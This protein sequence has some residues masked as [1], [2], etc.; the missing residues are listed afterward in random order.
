MLVRNFAG[1][2]DAVAHA[3]HDLARLDLETRDV[4]YHALRRALVSLIAAFP[5]YRTYA[6]AG[7]APGSDAPIL[8]RAVEAAK[9]MAGP[10]E[11]AIV[12]LVNGW[13]QG[14][15]VADQEVRARAVIALQQLCAPVAAK[16][17]EGHGLLPLR[18]AR[19]AQRRRLRSRPLRHPPRG[20]PRERHGARGA[21]PRVHA[22]HPRHTTTSAARTCAPAL[23]ALSEIPAEWADRIGAW[24]DL[25]KRHTQDAVDPA[26]EYVLYQMLLGAWPYDLAPDDADGLAQLGARLA[27]WQEKALRE[28]KLNSSWTAP[29]EDY[30][31]A[32]TRFVEAVTNPRVAPR[33]PRVGPRLRRGARAGGG[34]ERA[35]PDL[36]ALHHARRAGLL[37]GSRVLGLLPRRPGQPRPRRLRGARGGF[38]V[39]RER[40]GTIFAGA[41][42][43]GCGSTQ[44]LIGVPC[45]TRAGQ[46]PDLFAQAVLLPLAGSPAHHGRRPRSSPRLTHATPPRA[47]RRRLRPAH[48]R[49]ADA[50]ANAAGDAVPPRLVEATPRIVIPRPTSI[51]SEMRDALPRRCAAPFGEE[52]RVADLLGGPVPTGLWDAGVRPRSFRV[53]KR[54]RNPEI[55]ST[56]LHRLHPRGC[57]SVRLHR[58]HVGDLDQARAL[59]RREVSR[60]RDLAAEA[61]H[62]LVRAGLGV[63]AVG[64]VD[65]SWE[66][67]TTTLS[68]AS[69]LRRAYIRASSPCHAP[70]ATDRNW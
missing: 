56:P 63:V 24:L 39:R 21:L 65:L 4:T 35:R 66:T 68:R 53:A 38:F 9:D 8:E 13:I 69:V 27:R 7:A 55:A 58:A 18:A 62:A 17:V 47:A 34:R 37:P 59:G 22:R 36:P 20:L 30:E 12:D 25:N 51:D 3:F 6:T 40:R 50:A 5:A 15:G 14:I 57:S 33:L 16:A 2:L 31:A 70:S 29:D 41:G 23:A 42:G 32:C 1:Q 67:S 52:T 61:V 45:S 54:A 10:G 28:G 64:G 26:D 43:D 60:Q 44:A 49:P 11:A 19:L 46:Q 48:R